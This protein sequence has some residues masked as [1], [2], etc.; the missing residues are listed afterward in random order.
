MEK[1]NFNLGGGASRSLKAFTL[2]EVLITLAII[3][4]VA[5]LTIPSVITNYKNQEI[6]TR[7]KKTFTTLANTTNLAIKDYGSIASWHLGDTNSGAAAKDFNDKFLIPYLRVMKDCGVSDEGTCLHKVKTLNNVES[8]LTGQYYSKFFLADGTFIATKISRSTASN[9]GENEY[10][11][12]QID[13]NGEQKP[14]MYGRD[15][16]IFNYTI[17]S[18]GNP[19]GK[20]V[21]Y[22][23]LTIDK[24]H[25]NITSDYGCRIGGLGSYCS[26]VLYTNNWQ[27]P[28]RDKF[29]EIAKSENYRSQ[30][31]W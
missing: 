2:A 7:L 11:E 19:V 17:K 14:N 5:A 28:D 29:V 4:V 30:Y 31:P 15:Y 10:L 13:I 27:I 8:N 26:A 21:P 24:A 9:G 20:L 1:L 6:A 22:G 25:M 16:F 3:G 12:I 23:A 18:K